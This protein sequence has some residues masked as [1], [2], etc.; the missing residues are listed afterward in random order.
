ME[1][2]AL[3][4]ADNYAKWGLLPAE[5]GTYFQALHDGETKLN[6]DDP[7]ELRE[8]GRV[9][10]YAFDK[11]ATV[12]IATPQPVTGRVKILSGQINTADLSQW[13]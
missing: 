4:L 2:T 13:T 12:S 3:Y 9:T 8:A 5:N 1:K 7:H 10:R 11:W 6:T